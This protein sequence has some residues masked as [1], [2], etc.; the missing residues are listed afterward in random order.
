MAN[1]KM[2]WKN[3]VANMP[4]ES[5]TSVE[6]DESI[7]SI[8]SIN[9]KNTLTLPEMVSFVSDVTAMVIDPDE[10][11]YT[12]ESFDFAI[13]LGVMQHYAGIAFPSGR[14]S[15]M[16]GMAN[17]AYSILYSTN[18]YER[19]FAH[20]NRDQFYA[21]QGAIEERINFN[22]EMIASTAAK[23]ISELMTK[24]DEMLAEGQNALNQ[25]DSEQFAEALANISRVE[26]VG[27]TGKE[28]SN[29]VIP[30]NPS[31]K[32]GE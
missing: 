1:K 29:S 10:A 26:L 18:L 23:K 9:V 25:I 6:L 7:F 17:K 31:A 19:I 32:R 16:K 3:L 13:R 22:R 5:I 20:I 14:D 8:P 2:N 15:V 28:A 21:M 4:D 11:E 27:S 24:M 12:P 30:I